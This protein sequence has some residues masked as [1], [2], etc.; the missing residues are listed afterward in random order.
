MPSFKTTLSR[1]KVSEAFEWVGH[2]TA[3]IE[4]FVFVSGIA[5]A[6]GYS[7]VFGGLMQ[8]IAIVIY[9]W[10]PIFILVLLASIVY[11]GWMLWRQLKHSK[12]ER[13]RWF[14]FSLFY[15][16]GGTILFLGVAFIIK[17]TAMS[18]S[19]LVSEAMP[20]HSLQVPDSSTAS[21]TTVNP[22]GELSR[23]NSL[24]RIGVETRELLSRAL[25]TQSQVLHVFPASKLSVRETPGNAAKRLNVDF[26][27]E[28]VIISK[29]KQTFL[30]RSRVWDSRQNDFLRF[31]KGK[32]VIEISSPDLEE[33]V[34]QTAHEIFELLKLNPFGQK[35]K[36]LRQ[37]TPYE[38]YYKGRGY[39]QWLSLKGFE[40][41]IRSFRQGIKLDP[42]YPLPYA[43]IAQAYW[44]QGIWYG[45]QGKTIIQGEK[46]QL[47]FKAAKKAVELGPDLPECHL[48][49]AYALWYQ[50]A[51][52]AAHKELDITDSLLN[53]V[54]QPDPLVQSEWYILRGFL[55]DSLQAQER[56]F[57]KA[58]EKDSSSVLAYE[59][60]SHVYTKTNRFSRAQKILLTALEKV[61]GSALLYGVLASIYRRLNQP[62]KALDMANKA[63]EIMPQFADA[64]YEKGFAYA[65]L[66][67]IS[68]GIRECKNAIRINPESAYV[69]NYFIYDDQ[70]LENLSV[71]S[72]YYTRLIQNH[73]GF[74]FGY[75]QHG[76]YL[77]LKGVFE[78]RAGN[79]EKAEQLFRESIRYYQ[80]VRQLDP[81]SGISALNMAWAYSAIHDNRSI[82][83]SRIATEQLPN[84]SV[85]HSAYGWLLTNKALE[86][87]LDVA[88][89]SKY[90]AIAEPELEKARK[91][92]PYTSSIP[93]TLGNIYF[94][95]AKYDKA[96]RAYKDA[97]SLWAE[98]EK[99][100]KKLKEVKFLRLYNR[101]QKSFQEALAWVE[102]DSLYFFDYVMGS[103][104]YNISKR[105][106]PNAKSAMLYARLLL[107]R[108]NRD[109]KDYRRAETLFNL[110]AERNPESDIHS[111]ALAF[112][113]LAIAYRFV[114]DSLYDSTY[115]YFKRAITA[116][117][118]FPEI[119][120]LI[121]KFYWNHNQ[122]EAG[123]PYLEKAVQLDST[124]YR[125]HRLLGKSFHK[126][127]DYQ[128]AIA[129]Y[130]AFLSHDST[131]SWVCNDMGNCYYALGNYSAAIK[132]YKN[133]LRSDPS[134]NIVWSNLGDGYSKRN[135]YQNAFSAYQKA[136]LLKPQDA[137]YLY[138][139][140]RMQHKLNDDKTALSYIEQALTLNPGESKYWNYKGII[141]EGLQNYQ[142]ASE[143]YQKA[144]S[145]NPEDYILWFN[146]GFLFY[147]L[148][149]YEKALKYFQK[150]LRLNDKYYVGWYYYGVAL[151]KLNKEDKALRA[152]TK[153]LSLK[154]DNPV[155]WY[156]RG[157]IYYQE[158]KYRKALRD[159]EQACRLTPDDID[160]QLYLGFARYFTSDYK[161]A[162]IAFRKVTKLSPDN[163]SSWMGLAWSY[164]LLNQPQ[165]AR[166]AASRALELDPENEQIK[167]LM[168]RLDEE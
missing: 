77:Y 86:D 155:L 166:N 55:S 168:T 138:Q 67:L 74:A 7:S 57:S 33:A 128:N 13:S 43:G 69:L 5:G 23:S 22:T 1:L 153:A 49:L 76:N 158:K 157:L 63:I 152:Y 156:N 47:A 118:T 11:A 143:A 24:S 15:L 130:R 32:E 50:G 132:C 135:D 108:G 105:K 56:L 58:I 79:S 92:N 28:T 25:K 136:H 41:A 64:H 113:Y 17:P 117:S 114:S 97:L 3:A 48:A 18:L 106:P 34:K 95:Q 98:Y 2:A 163:V 133:S 84:W 61:P 19:I 89:R 149:R 59:E 111:Q 35:D 137:N 90:L 146:H 40:E 150:S 102:S 151:D 66:G 42:T 141:Y 70:T 99:V 142:M 123:I 8:E 82:E 161:G 101:G 154:Q 65:E 120:Y 167:H 26:A 148:K 44:L 37:A 104:S 110:L 119:H 54:I 139:M 140:A 20:S 16:I 81:W 14:S 21:S 12:E 72:L 93:S 96:I 121:G 45:W 27:L 52:T 94:L 6:L 51:R 80:K 88:T 159:F 127:K 75:L 125:S 4:A 62:E 100:E 78:S 53:N 91:L 162:V 115:A 144:C 164:Y 83:L 131:D 134:D 60:L 112:K 147:N 129:H 39:Y 10:K 29:E 160:F 107:Y 71:D 87:T 116:D 38:L 30:L 165:K 145:L 36:S 85:A 109:K 31:S 126:T 9:N 103:L 122:I 124:H 68:R 73:P 46:N